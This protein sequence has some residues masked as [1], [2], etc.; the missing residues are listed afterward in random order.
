[1]GIDY[2]TRS[3]AVEMGSLKLEMMYVLQ[4]GSTA[5]A[6]NSVLQRI[7]NV[8]STERHFYVEN[9]IYLPLECRECKVDIVPEVNQMPTPISRSETRFGT[10]LF[11]HQGSDFSSGK[12]KTP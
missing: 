6:L 11:K 7:M 1:M 2:R 5:S 4:D 10:P 12:T 8:T 9:K 3:H